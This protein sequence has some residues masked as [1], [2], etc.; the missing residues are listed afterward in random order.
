MERDEICPLCTKN[1]IRKLVSLKKLKFQKSDQERQAETAQCCLCAC[2]YIYVY[3]TCVM[4]LGIAFLI[5][6]H[7]ILLVFFLVKI[8]ITSAQANH[9]FIVTYYSNA[10]NILLTS[11]LCYSSCM[12][13]GDT[14][15]FLSQEDLRIIFH[16]I[17]VAKEEARLRAEQV[18]SE[19]YKILSMQTRN[20]SG[21]RFAG[22][23]QSLLFSF[24]T[25]CF[26][27]FLCFNFLIYTL[28]F[29][30]TDT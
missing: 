3:I 1:K 4:K 12:M 29:L 19:I 11:H 21:R 20:L 2:I 13:C 25:V 27:S 8:A 9:A 26:L 23:S 30:I 6:L 7:F 15:G 18:R 24:S 17:E 16:E 28:L 10:Y 5:Q 22:L 14:L